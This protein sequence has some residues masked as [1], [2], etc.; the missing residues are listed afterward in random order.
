MEL[1][2]C[3]MLAGVGALAL[4]EVLWKKVP[5]QHPPLKHKDRIGIFIFWPLVMVTFIVAF[6]AGLIK[7]DK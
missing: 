7:G 1:I 5:H 3:Y 6:I 2:L 4:M